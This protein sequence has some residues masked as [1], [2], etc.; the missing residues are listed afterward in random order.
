MSTPGNVRKY[1]TKR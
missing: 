1:K